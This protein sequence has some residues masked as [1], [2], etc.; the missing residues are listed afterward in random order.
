MPRGASPCCASA[1][2]TQGAITFT[3]AVRGDITFQWAD[4]GDFVALRADLTPT[5]LLA[6]AIDDLAMGINFVAR[7]EDLLSVTPRQLLLY[8]ALL[9]DGLLD[10]VLAATS[11]RRARPT[12]CRRRSRTCRCWSGPTASP[13]RSATAPSRSTSS[14][15]R[16]SSPRRC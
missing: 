9:A 4:V 1:P 8:D 15:A 6:N 5:Y 14:A 2:A 10:R 11:A 3:D 16:A 13:C 7:G 12:R